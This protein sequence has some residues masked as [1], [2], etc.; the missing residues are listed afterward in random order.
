[1]PNKFEK[2]AEEAQFLTDEQ[3]KSRFSS[4][5]RFS[6]EDTL[7]IMKDTGISKE[8]LA[9]LIAEVKKAGEINNKTSQTVSGIKGGTETL[10]AITK[11]LL[12]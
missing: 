4:L 10:V 5:T 11:R 9:T 3:F 8:D 1:M 2:L 7:K 12:L 6:E